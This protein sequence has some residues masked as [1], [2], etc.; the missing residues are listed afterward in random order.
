MINDPTGNAVSS[1]YRNYVSLTMQ[2]NHGL[3][4]GSGSEI[5]QLPRLVQSCTFS[6]TWRT[7]NNQA[8]NLRRSCH[9]A[10]GT[11]SG[12]ADASQQYV[13]NDP[14]LF[15]WAGISRAALNP[16][17]AT[18]ESY[19]F[20]ME[21]CDSEYYTFYHTPRYIA[22]ATISG[23][24]TKTLHFDWIY[25]DRNMKPQVLFMVDLKCKLSS[26]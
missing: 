9:E 16:P 11:F 10:T 24:G 7:N 21:T 26:P 4:T 25:K 3:S 23:F 1:L 2:P 19:S 14:D 22:Q 18:H 12:Y 15:R 5:L 13:T 8:F 17:A 6:G 20:W